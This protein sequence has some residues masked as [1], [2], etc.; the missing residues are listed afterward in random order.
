MLAIKKYTK[1]YFGIHKNNDTQTDK[2][3]E[4]V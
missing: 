3:H 1:L 2:L 4:I